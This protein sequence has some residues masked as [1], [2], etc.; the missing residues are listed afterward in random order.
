[1]TG[2]VISVDDTL[3]RKGACILSSSGI[4]LPYMGMAVGIVPYT[5]YRY[6]RQPKKVPA[7]LMTR[8]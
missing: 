8:P 1:M 7:D 4:V 3:R 2:A 6:N 5:L